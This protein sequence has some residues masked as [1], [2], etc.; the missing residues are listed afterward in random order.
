MTP[1]SRNGKIALAAV[2]LASV[3]LYAG[4]Y[5]LRQFDDNRLTSWRWVFDHV[6]VLPVALAICACAILAALVSAYRTPTPRVIAVLAFVLG[7]FFWGQ[8]EVIVD[9]SRYFTQAKHLSQ[10]GVIYYLAEW[11]G[12]IEP[13]TD[14]PLVPFIFGMGFKIFGESRLVVQIL[15]TSAFAGTVWLTALSAG[16]L[17]DREGEED[18]SSMSAGLLLAIPY[19]YTQVPMM[20]VDVACMFFLVLG[21]FSFQRALGRGGWGYIAFAS[22]SIF[23]MLISKYSQWMLASVYLMLFLLKLKEADG[24]SEK[25]DKLSERPDRQEVFRRGMAVAIFTSLMFGAFLL[26]YLDVVRAQMELLVSYQKPGLRRWGESFISTFIF[27]THPFVSFG[28]IVSAVIAFKRRDWRWVVVAWLV[29]LMFVMRIER[30]RYMVPLFPMLAIAAAYGVNVIGH[31]RIRRLVVTVAVFCSFAL[32]S[33]AFMPYLKTNNL[34]NLME[35]GRFLNQKDA[36]LVQVY[37]FPQ[38]SEINPAVAVPILDLYTDAPV[39]YLY[40]LRPLLHMEKIETSPFRFTWTYAN[41]GYYDHR[42]ERK[43]SDLAVISF[44]SDEKNRSRLPVGYSLVNRFETSE[45]IFRFKPYVSLYERKN[46]PL[47]P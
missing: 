17:F 38:K 47:N 2:P 28:A 21:F 12:A 3:L 39:E 33:S 30:I 41:P 1:E 25:P 15:T 40:D 20:L 7:A 8:P 16:D 10:Y 29:M 46:Y 45:G 9:V 37:A 34:V 32:A 26:S 22:V 43:P 24:L 31:G 4:L 19:L 36:S 14:M 11:G 23:F 42:A 5:G 27:Q 6:D 35:A 44:W 18:I 13:W